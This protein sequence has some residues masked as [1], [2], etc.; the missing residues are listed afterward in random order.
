MFNVRSLLLQSCKCRKSALH[1]M[2]HGKWVT[3]PY[4]WLN[5]IIARQR[6]GNTQ[7]L[8]KYFYWQ[9]LF[10]LLLY[11]FIKCF[12]PQDFTSTN[13]YIFYE[14]FSIKLLH[15]YNCF[16]YLECNYFKIQVLII[17]KKGIWIFEKS[18]VDGLWIYRCRIIHWLLDCTVDPWCKNK[19]C[20]SISQTHRWCAK[21]ANLRTLSNWLCFSAFKKLHWKL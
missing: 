21:C 15:F 2:Y 5:R 9:H 16:L 10:I 3:S 1:A 18:V 8:C 13:H 14:R 6:G 11:C 17:K 19:Q 12:M 4:T 20:G 7:V